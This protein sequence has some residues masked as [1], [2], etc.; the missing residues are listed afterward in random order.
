[1]DVLQHASMLSINL[2]M[3]LIF[4]YKIC[5]QLLDPSGELRSRVPAGFFK[6][7]LQNKVIVSGTFNHDTTLL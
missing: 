2:G 7:P 1:M 5:L 3:T 4:L 6:N